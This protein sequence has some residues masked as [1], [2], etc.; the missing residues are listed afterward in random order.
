MDPE[1]TPND[2]ARNYPNLAGWAEDG[3]IEIGCGYTDSFIKVMD[4]G[5]VVWEGKE[6]YATIDEALQ[7]AEIRT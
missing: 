5:G 3:M 7:D 4:E 6:K 1:I 2:F